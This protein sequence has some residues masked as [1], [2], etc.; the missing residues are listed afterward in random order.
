MDA[1][2]SLAI[3]R[4]TATLKEA[5]CNCVLLEDPTHVPKHVA[6]AH[7]MFVLIKNVKFFIDIILPAA[8]WSWF[9]LNL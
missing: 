2:V 4:R 8:V 3:Y 5:K 6:E 7:L 9:R 1:F